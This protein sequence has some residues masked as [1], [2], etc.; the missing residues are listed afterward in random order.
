M[1]KN[2]GNLKSL[3]TYRKNNKN[4]LA[5]KVSQNKYGYSNENKVLTLPFYYLPFYLDE[6]NNIDN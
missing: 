6:I 2:K 4:D 1:K 3:E 5:I